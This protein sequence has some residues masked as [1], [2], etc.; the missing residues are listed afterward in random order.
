MVLEETSYYMQ[1]QKKEKK[2]KCDK[3]QWDRY[4]MR[5]ADAGRPDVA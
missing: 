5:A 3:Q 4:L 1:K 2:K